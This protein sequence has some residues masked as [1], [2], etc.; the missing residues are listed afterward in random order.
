MIISRD[1]NREDIKV[2][3][4]KDDKL[5]L[6]LRLKKK[7]SSFQKFFEDAAYRFLKRERKKDEDEKNDNQI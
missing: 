4:D 6:F 7:R 3:M 5:E 2:R 1:D